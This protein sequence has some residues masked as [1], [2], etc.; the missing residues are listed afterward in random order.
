MDNS[1]LISVAGFITIAGGEK[2]RLHV[3][4]GLFFFWLGLVRIERRKFKLVTPADAVGWLLLGGDEHPRASWGEVILSPN[5][6]SWKR[7]C[8]GSA[9]SM[10][11]N[12][13]TYQAR[14]NIFPL[15]WGIHNLAATPSRVLAD[16]PQWHPDLAG[17]IWKEKWEQLFCTVTG[18]PV[19]LTARWA[20]S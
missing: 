9:S 3:L 8:R 17:V 19:L 11:R 4:S 6:Y 12:V 2:I 18:T 1:W 20:L 7:T 15:A 13:V 14:S 16:I 5:T 10:V